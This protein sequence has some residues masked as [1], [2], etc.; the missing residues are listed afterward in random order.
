MDDETS[1]GPADDP[2]SSSEKLLPLAIL[3]ALMREKWAAGDGDGAAEL[4]RAAAPYLHPRRASVAAFAPVD[5]ELHRASDAELAR[6]LALVANGT[7]VAPG[8]P[9]LAD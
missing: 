1:C 9:Q 2:G 4:A 8:D 7:A 6:R 3:L 5:V